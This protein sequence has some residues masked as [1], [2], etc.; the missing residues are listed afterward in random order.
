[1]SEIMI[2]KNGKVFDENGRFVEKEVYIKDGRIAATREEVTD[3]EVVDAAGLKVIPGLVDVHSHGA[4]GHDFSDGDT[5]GLR[6]VLRYEKKNGITSYCPTS[7]TLG[8]EQLRNIFRTAVEAQNTPDGARIIGVN[9]E[10]PFLDEE[11]KGA[12]EAKYIA[13][14]TETMWESCQNAA[15]GLIKLVTLAPNAKGAM[16]FID[17]YHNQV[18][19][20]L[21]HTA[22]GY[23]IAKEALN[24]GA[25]HITHLYNAMLPMG[26]REPGMVIAAVEDEKCMVELISDGIHIHP[27]VVRNTFR[28]FGRNRVVLISDSMMA[29]GMENGTYQL[30]GQG[31]TVKDGRATLENG[32]IAG[33]ATNLFE[34]MRRAMTFGVPEEAALLAATRNPARSIGADDCVGVLAP[35]CYADILLV[36]ESYQIVKVIG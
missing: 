16:E 8:A 24:R 27:A 31:V 34:C 9:M 26:H 15:N 19:I 32:T 33:S 3:E 36:D 22:A 2:I 29:T 1:M 17:R 35:G 11:K 21:G 13:C 14:P 23:D 25:D 28:M 5:E 30:G 12:H 6:C 4:F 7:M 10:G 20:S 18:H